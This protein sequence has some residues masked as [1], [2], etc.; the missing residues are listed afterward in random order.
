MAKASEALTVTEPLKPMDKAAVAPD[1][2]AAQWSLKACSSWL[3][4]QEF[5]ICPKQDSNIVKVG[6]GSHCDIIFPGTHL[7]REH[8]QLKIE[9]GQIHVKDLNSVN[10]T[11]INDVRITEGIVRP[12]DKLRLDV[13]SFNVEGPDISAAEPIAVQPE[14]QVP[15]TG[16][17]PEQPPEQLPKAA[18][19]K[20]WVTQP[21]SP[22]NRTNPHSLNSEK[23]STAMW[24]LTCA[25]MLAISAVGTY[26]IFFSS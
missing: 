26:I 23:P 17:P 15:V 9:H 4:G 12:G 25:L 8:A 18:P 13:Y 20:R 11:F 14:A 24:V 22:G 10:G 1:K 21:T 6:R 3:A 5:V 7:S 19:E 2:A 16:Q